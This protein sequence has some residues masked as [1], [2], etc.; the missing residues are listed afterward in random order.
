MNFEC[1]ICGHSFNFAEGDPDN[2]IH[3]GAGLGDPHEAYECPVCG[4]THNTHHIHTA[5]LT[6]TLHGIGHGFR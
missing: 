5:V 4:S 1:R 3:E 6:S 2:G